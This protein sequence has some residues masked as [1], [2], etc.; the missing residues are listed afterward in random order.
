MQK[1]QR[2]LWADLIGIASRSHARAMAILFG[3]P[4]SLT[5]EAS[6]DHGSRGI[7]PSATRQ[8]HGVISALAAIISFRATS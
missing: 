3:A 7:S 1:W 5:K 2:V 8:I 4:T 6:V